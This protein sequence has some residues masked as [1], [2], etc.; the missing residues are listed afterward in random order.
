[1]QSKMKHSAFA[2]GNGGFTYI[3]ALAALSVAALIM[4]AMPAAISYFASM[5][6]YGHDFEADF[7]VLD[8]TDIYKESEKIT[9]SSVGTSV[10]FDDGKKVISYRR[11]GNRIIRSVDGSGF[12]TVMYGVK[13]FD[14]SDEGADVR[15]DIESENGEFNETF[16]FKK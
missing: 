9:V 10:S 14:I 13:K 7:F 2:S 11:A 16:T 15:L 1:M 8:I 6:D 4:T 12:I 3:E 5:S